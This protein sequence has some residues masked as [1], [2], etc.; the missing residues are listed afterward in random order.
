[1]SHTPES[2]QLTDVEVDWCCQHAID[3][4]ELSRYALALREA[5]KRLA[6]VLEFAKRVEIMGRR[7]GR[8]VAADLRGIVAEGK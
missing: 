4:T 6:T 2:D 7:D 3:G 1:M 8:H 5:R